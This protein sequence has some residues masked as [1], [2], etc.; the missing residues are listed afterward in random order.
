MEAYTGSIWA[1][2]FDYPP[3]NSPGTWALCNGATYNISDYQPL[4]S[5]IGTTYGGDASTF[6]VPNLMAT[7]QTP[8][9]YM[10]IGTGQGLNLTNRTLA[11]TGGSLYLNLTAANI[12]AHSHPFTVAPL[13]AGVPAGITTPVN[14]YYG[15]TSANA[16]NDV[17]SAAPNNVMAQNNVPSSVTGGAP[18]SA[19]P[20]G[21]QVCYCICL[22]GVWPPHP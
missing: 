6:K 17:Q 9:G 20:S 10:P 5:L 16:Y 19:F 1:F 22:S 21:L 2:S 13:R 14:A 12:P 3:A 4:Y 8:M 15:I 7:S 18:I 11:Q